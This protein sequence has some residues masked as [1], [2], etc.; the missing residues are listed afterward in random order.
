MH[1]ESD[2]ILSCLLLHLGLKSLRWGHGVQEVHASDQHKFWIVSGFLKGWQEAKEITGCAE[3]KRFFNNF[4][5]LLQDKIC[6]QLSNLTGHKFPIYSFERFFL[7]LLLPDASDV[8][9]SGRKMNAEGHPT[10]KRR[11]PGKVLGSIPVKLELQN[12]TGSGFS[13][14]QHSK[15]G[16]DVTH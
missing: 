2:Q 10:Q 1:Q 9:K 4:R 7:S 6:R 11:F 13:S 16:P 14:A 12:G 5:F 15:L 8:D 3:W